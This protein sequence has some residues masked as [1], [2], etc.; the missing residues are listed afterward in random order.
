V[1]VLVTGATGF[2]GREILRQLRAAGHSIRNLARD[3]QSQRALEAA[4][5]H[6]AEVFPGDVLDVSSL[7]GGLAGVDAVIHLVGIIS[8][9]GRSTFENIHTRGT[10]NVVAATRAAGVKRLAHMSALGTRPNAAS[11]YHQTKWAA[12]EIIRRSGLAWTIF[13]PSIIHGA[14]D[15]FVNLFARTSRLSPWL[16]VMGSGESKFQPVPVEVVAACFVKSLSEPR[17]IGQ[18]Y[19]LCG[20]EVL[21]LEQILDLILIVTGRRRWKLHLPW[22]LVR[23]QAAFLEGVFPRLLGKPP[24]LNRDQLIMLRED[25]VGDPEPAMELFGLRPGPFREGIGRYLGRNA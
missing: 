22:W 9:A 17:A 16:P 24:P 13:R 15:G 19:D 21:T 2:V 1:K 23:A 6:G 10:E 18:T 25:N 8:E 20:T 3:P 5:R 12:E 4:T 7:P 11:R 14:N